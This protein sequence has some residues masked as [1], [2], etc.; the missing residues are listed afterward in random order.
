MPNQP[1]WTVDL[2]EECH[3]MC[4]A[5]YSMTC[6][7]MYMPDGCDFSLTVDFLSLLVAQLQSKQLSKGGHKGTYDIVMNA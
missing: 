6:M 4:I 7:H 3:I 5:K 1:T 2:K